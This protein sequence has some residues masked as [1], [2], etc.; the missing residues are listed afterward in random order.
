MTALNQYQRLEASGLWRPSPDAQRTEVIVSVGDATLVISDRQERALTHWSLAAVE[1][2]NP[3]RRPAIYH[4][5][6][7]PGETLELAE[8]ET[9]MIAAIEKLRAAIERQR[10]HPGRLRL[11]IVL[12]VLALIAAAGILWL[13][14]ALRAHAVAVVP[15]VKRAEIGAALFR[16]VQRVTGPPCATPEGRAALDKLARRIPGPDGP[17][18]LAVMRDGVRGTVHLPGA[19]ILIGRALVE[20]HDEPDVVAGYL[21]AERLRSETRDPLALLLRQSPIWASLRLLTT[22]DLDDATLSAYAE[23]LLTRPVPPVD[24]AALLA[25]FNAWSVRSTPYAYA[26]D[27]S[28]E[29]TLGLI[30]ADPFE[31]QT[32]PPILSDADWLRLQA[33]CGG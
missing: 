19:T 30:E 29:T 18:H 21:V 27:D 31:G 17:G 10:P 9:E 23:T 2:A 26:V 33:I 8:N 14:Q 32:P 3:G 28:G 16:H 5:D 25:G 24:D 12:I 4:P 13:P 15:Q 11:V 22:G 7:D 1:R 6:G 20:D